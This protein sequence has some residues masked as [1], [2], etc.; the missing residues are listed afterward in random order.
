ME[1]GILCLLILVALCYFETLLASSE[2]KYPGLILPL[3]FF[4]FTVVMLFIVA[5]EFN[6][7]KA[8]FTLLFTNIPTYILLLIY[9]LKH[10]K[11]K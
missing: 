2:K 1:Y 5:D 9:K 8:V 11:A 3:L 6:I 10:K 4:I 7:I